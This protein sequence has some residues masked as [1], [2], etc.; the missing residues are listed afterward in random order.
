MRYYNVIL[1]NTV[2][3]VTELEFNC[4][5]KETALKGFSMLVSILEDAAGIRKCRTVDGKLK[6]LDKGFIVINN[7]I[8]KY[9]ELPVNYIVLKDTEV[10]YCG[11]DPIFQINLNDFNSYTVK[12]YPESFIE[13]T[14]ADW[15]IDI[16]IV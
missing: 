6:C 15:D 5:E 4:K 1:Y 16:C 12:R 13:E 8:V 9:F 3:Q 11:Q 7:Y 14:G 10:V 2:T